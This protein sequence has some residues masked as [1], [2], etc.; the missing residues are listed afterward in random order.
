M[1]NDISVIICTYNR[2][3]MLRETLES[4][5]SVDNTES[6][7]ELL[8]VDNNSPDHTPQVV[9]SFRPACPGQ[10][11]YVCET[12]VGLSYARNRGIKEASGNIVAFVD[13]D[14]LFDKSWL[15]ELLKAFN[16]HQ[17][18]SCAG[19]KSIPKF[20]IEQPGW[21]TKDVFSIYGSTGS[22]DHDK[23][24]VFPKHPFGLNMA[25]RKAVFTQVGD[26]NIKFGLNKKKFLVYNDERELFYR[27]SQA[28]LKVFY[29]SKAILY[30]RIPKER[31]S[32]NYLLKRYYWQGVS[33][34]VFWQ[35]NKP[36][37]KFILFLKTVR[38]LINILLP[39]GKRSP[40]NIYLYY[41]LFS[42]NDKLSIYRSL[43]T[44]KQN[45]AEI[46]TISK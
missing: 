27:I 11:R 7:V 31:T 45:L 6:N 35:L 9:E 10:L 13:D 8:I 38:S 16:D 30:H 4:W 26:F 46:F 39:S 29:A 14:V 17:E 37:T 19:G 3:E 44:V 20:E 34:V 5:R 43:G 24:M 15:N 23:F 41:K 2:A 1:L 22:G 25:F 21:I 33:D 36:R 42:F 28:G 32:K 40:K 18:I 12:N